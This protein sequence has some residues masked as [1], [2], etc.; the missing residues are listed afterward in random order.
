MHHPHS[1]PQAARDAK[2]AKLP[3]LP[4]GFSGRLKRGT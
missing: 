3:T 4:V 1:G 2:D